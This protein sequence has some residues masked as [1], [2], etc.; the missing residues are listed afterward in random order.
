MTPDTRTEIVVGLSAVAAILFLWFANRSTSAAPDGG[1][2]SLSIPGNA[3]PATAPGAAANY[4]YS[5]S[6]STYA[7]TGG[8]GSTYSYS[9]G[10]ISVTG[11]TIGGNTF[12]GITYPMGA[13]QASS[14]N[15]AGQAG[16]AWASMS[17]LA[18]AMAAVPGYVAGLAGGLTSWN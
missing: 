15:C 13:G 2:L 3:N 4:N 11:P 16:P 9:A 14:C 5:G 10:D 1:S 18:S 6:P 7:F 12:G 8:T 17:D